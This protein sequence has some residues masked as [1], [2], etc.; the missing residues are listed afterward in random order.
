MRPSEL[1]FVQ[2][3]IK[4]MQQRIHEADLQIAAKTEA[5]NKLDIDIENRK[6]VISDLVSSGNAD[7]LR[8]EKINADINSVGELEELITS[9]KQNAKQDDETRQ[10][11]YDELKV[12]RDELQEKLTAA[13]LAAAELESPLKLLKTT[14][15]V[16]GGYSCRSDGNRNQ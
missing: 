7:K 3:S 12:N 5:K 11:K 8:I 6:R 4:D 1:D 13:R 9:K 15:S 14:F 10:K 2:S 16:C